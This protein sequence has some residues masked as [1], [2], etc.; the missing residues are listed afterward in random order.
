MAATKADA[1]ARCVADL[2]TAQQQLYDAVTKEGPM[3]EAA[4]SARLTVESIKAAQAAL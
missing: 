1:D 3:S 4:R 2:A